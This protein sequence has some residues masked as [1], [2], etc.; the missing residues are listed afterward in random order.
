MVSEELVRKALEK[1]KDPE[2]GISIVRL[3][4]VKKVGV[5]SGKVQI[6]VALTISGCPLREK[7]E[8]DVTEAVSA[9]DGVR[10]VKVNL[11]VMA[12]EERDELVAGLTG[13]KQAEYFSGQR[14]KKVIPV[15][16]GKGGVGKSTVTANLAAALAASGYKVGVIDAD[17][18]GF[19]IPQM[20]G[21]S[22]RPTVINEMIIP[23]QKDGVKIISIGFLVPEDAS[24]IWRGPM[25]HKAIT[26]FMTDVFWGDLDFLLLDL[27]PGTGDVSITVAQAL[28]EAEILIVTT[29]QKVAYN[30]AARISKLAEVAHLK[31][32][33]VVENMSYF[34]SPQGEKI[35]IFGKGGGKELAQKLGVPLLGEIPIETEIREGSD[36]GRPV[37]IY[38]RDSA[39][40]QLYAQIAEKIA[41]TLP[42]PRPIG[43]VS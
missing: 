33:G 24:V 19:S 20:L 10:S 12:K 7:V 28:P 2:L 25:L 32:L 15:A 29:P 4:M 31:I 16:S 37:S 9:I 3:G 17:V 42:Q 11:G 1:V 39:A 35:H 6:D 36:T 38:R 18:Y 21:A 27:P 8:K 13:R 41:A 43:A 30:V 34:Q 22:G 14:P 23:I 5:E 26:Q 40:G